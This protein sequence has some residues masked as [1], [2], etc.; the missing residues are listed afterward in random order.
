MRQ[1]IHAAHDYVAYLRG[2]VTKYKGHRLTRPRPNSTF[3]PETVH[4]HARG[5]RSFSFPRRSAIR[6]SS[7]GNAS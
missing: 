6:K 2:P 5:L 1:T 7:V 4:T 3:L